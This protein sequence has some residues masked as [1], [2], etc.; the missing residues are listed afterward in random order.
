MR[1]VGTVLITAIFCSTLFSQQ[2]PLFTHFWHSNQLYNP[3]VT[4]L[5]HNHEANLLARW[6]WIGV[7]GA[8]D[9]QLGSYGVKLENQNSGLGVN[10]MRNSIGF[11]KNNKAVVSYAYHLKFANESSLSFG[12]AAGVQVHSFDGSQFIFPSPNQEPFSSYTKAAFI[13]DFGLHFKNKNLSLGLSS[14]GLNEPRLGIYQVAR[15]YYLTGAYDV[16]LNEKWNLQPK[17]IVVTDAVKMSAQMHLLANFNKF[18]TFGGGYRISDAICVNASYQ[19]KEKIRIGYSYD[20]TI[21]KLS[22]ISSGS[23]E[24]LLGI[25]F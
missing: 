19:F 16:E 12:A 22:N 10:Y 13:A 17:L 18:L 4:G 6:S 5:K 7:N 24:V 3:A 2:D 14:T 8:P 23:H 21:N 20:L 9:T 15:H 25:T 1:H 11:S